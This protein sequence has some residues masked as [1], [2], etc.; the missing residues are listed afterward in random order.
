[1]MTAHARYQQQTHIDVWQ[2]L[3]QAYELVASCRSSS[4]FPNR[5]DMPAGFI[6]CD[7]VSSSIAQIRDWVYSQMG[8]VK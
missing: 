6:S 2:K 5:S 8:E 4:V 3:E 7:N 1:M